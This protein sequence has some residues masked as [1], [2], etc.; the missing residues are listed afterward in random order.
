MPVVNEH[1]RAFVVAPIPTTTL[2]SISRLAAA[3]RSTDLFSVQGRGGALSA[4]RAEARRAAREAAA[5]AR[6]LAAAERAEEARLAAQARA[7]AAK[8]RAK[9]EREAIAA[10]GKP[11]PAARAQRLPPWL[12]PDLLT[13][14]ELLMTLASLLQV[15]PQ[16]HTHDLVVE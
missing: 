3:G 12:L 5:A 16:E 1:M 8:A 14:W 2:T 13:T 7:A 9:R 15:P 11:P 4:A 10:R 6:A